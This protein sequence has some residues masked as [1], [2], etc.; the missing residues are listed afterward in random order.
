MATQKVTVELPQAIF[1][2]LARIAS[3]TQQPLEVLAAQSIASNLPPTPDNAPVE[4][5]AELLQMQTWDSK[6]LIAIAQSQT[7]PEQQ[8]RHIELLEK[9]QN[10]ELT[11]SERR[12]LSELRIAADRLM[13]QKA[14]AW[15]IL[16]WRGH[17]VPAL[18]ELP[19]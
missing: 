9:N 17:R 11:Y 12:E 4:I 6:E 18:N 15:S 2:Q 16:R 8:Q 3:A 10:G 7:T 14:Y 19:E 1:Q 5:Q 13:L